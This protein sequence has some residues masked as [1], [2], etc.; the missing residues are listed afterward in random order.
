MRASLLVCS[1]RGIRIHEGI[2]GLIG[3]YEN[4][5]VIFSIPSRCLSVMSPSPDRM[6]KLHRNGSRGLYHIVKASILIVSSSQVFLVNDEIPSDNRLLFVDSFDE[7]EQSG[8]GL[9]TLPP[10]HVPGL[11]SGAVDSPGGKALFGLTVLAPG[12]T[13]LIRSTAGICRRIGLT[14]LG[15]YCSE[16]CSRE[17]LVLIEGD[18]SSGAAH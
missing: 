14:P 5:Q 10:S 8:P 13:F 2:P 18:Q 16:P 15:E 12:E 3:S 9:F 1:N 11:P 4:E 17:D 6:P 7:T